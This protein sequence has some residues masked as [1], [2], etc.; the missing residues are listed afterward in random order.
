MNCKVNYEQRLKFPKKHRQP[1]KKRRNLESTGEMD[2]ASP[3]EED[4][5]NPVTCSQCTTEVGVYDTDEVFHFF[6]VLASYS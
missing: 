4:L 6:N 1:T 3:D 2:V 5:Y